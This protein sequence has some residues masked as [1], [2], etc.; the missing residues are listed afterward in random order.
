MRRHEFEPLA[1]SCLDDLF[2]VSCCLVRTQQ[3]A[4][5]IV[6]EV[7][8]RAFRP[9]SIE[10]FEPAG[11]DHAESVRRWMFQI[12]HNVAMSSLK[13]AWRERRRNRKVSQDRREMAVPSGLARAER[14][15]DLAALPEALAMLPA[16]HREILVLSVVGG[17]K[18]REIADILSIPMGTVMSR[19]NRAK[20]VVAAHLNRTTEAPDTASDGEGFRPVKH[21]RVAL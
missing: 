17:L 5:D 9:A 18:Y 8:A 12:A 3:Q 21:L 7:Y 2:R 4:E 1:L 16:F 13:S 19:L 10:R 14:D 6:Q 15:D 11:P 20:V